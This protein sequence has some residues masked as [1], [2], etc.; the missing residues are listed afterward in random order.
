[1]IKLRVFDLFEKFSFNVIGPLYRNLG[2]RLAATGLKL[3]G[4]RTSDDRLVPSLRSKRFL[5]S[6]PSLAQA[7]FVAP[8]ACVIGN[9]KLGEGSSVWYGATLRGDINEIDVGRN[10]LLQDLV[11]VFPRAGAVRVGDNVLVGPN[12]HLESCHLEN[13]S[14]VGMGSTV[15]R[16][17]K[18]ESKAIVAAGAV[19]EEN[20]VVPANQVW[21]G[22]P[23]RY[24]RD[25]SAEEREVINEHHQELLQLA[26][27]H[28]EE[29]G[30]SLREIVNDM[31]RVE[32][33]N[34]MDVEEMALKHMKD[35]GFPI[36]GE[37]DDYIEQ[38]V[39]L[40]SNGEV[41]EDQLWR[42]N[43]DPFEQ[44]L[45]NFPDSFKEYKENYERVDEVRKYFEQN[46]HAQAQNIKDMKGTSAS[47]DP[48]QNRFSD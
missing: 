39:F 20:T 35:L 5:G 2:I 29:N 9:V 11:S 42:K 27:I 3:Q 30:K 32:D 8:N 13:N 23:A 38:R 40:K 22:N 19:V 24:L 12:A 16:G 28:S 33:E 41:S 17:A 18:V 26:R 43:Y 14:F 1:M 31:D 21:A 48:W 10:T 15:R 6:T 7:D 44:D 25:L 34:Y 36:D 46:P 47:Q 37:D 45:S 4:D